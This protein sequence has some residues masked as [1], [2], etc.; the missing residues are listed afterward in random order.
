MVTGIITIPLYIFHK[1]NYYK[2]K[3]KMKDDIEICL[4]EIESLH[5]HRIHVDKTLMNIITTMKFTGV[6]WQQ[7]F[8]EMK[9]DTV[10]M[11]HYSD[12]DLIE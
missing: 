12:E 5:K 2:E 6:D 9:L 3:E 8:I 11:H 7:K 1:T 10:Y 4:K